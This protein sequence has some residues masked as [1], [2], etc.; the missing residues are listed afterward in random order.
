MV[1]R[2]VRVLAETQVPFDIVTEQDA[3][4]LQGY[5]TLLVPMLRYL[6][7][8]QIGRLLSYARQGGNLVA[9]DPFGTEDKSARRRPTDPL[10][11]F[12]PAGRDFQA[13]A[14]GQG[15][16]LRLTSTAVPARRSDLWCLMEALRK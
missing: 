4:D 10:A 9:I 3:R 15:K 14:C 1:H 8:A 7:D 2:L 16:L 5:A 11:E 12:A 6:D 13:V